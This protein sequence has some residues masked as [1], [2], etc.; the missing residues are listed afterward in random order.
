V[1]IARVQLC[2]GGHEDA[3]NTIGWTSL[4]RRLVDFKPL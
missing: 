4:A 1:L 2:F 3:F